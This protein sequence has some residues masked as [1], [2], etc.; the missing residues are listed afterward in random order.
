MRQD[1]NQNICIFCSLHKVGYS[2]LEAYSKRSK[3]LLNF[4]KINI[5]ATPLENKLLYYIYLLIIILYDYTRNM[6]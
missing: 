2:D 1:E 5:D 4:N 6:W 3:E